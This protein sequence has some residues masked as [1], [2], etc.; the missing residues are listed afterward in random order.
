MKKNIIGTLV[1]S[2]FSTLGI[3]YANIPPTSPLIQPSVQKKLFNQATM[4]GSNIMLANYFVN[5]AEMRTISDRMSDLRFGIIDPGF[6]ARTYGGKLEPK[7]LKQFSNFSI[8]Y[9]G[10][11]FGFDKTLHQSDHVQWIIG[12]ELGYLHSKNHYKYAHGNNK[13]F[14]ATLYTTLF[15]DDHYY[16]E[17]FLKY[18]R[19]KNNYKFHDDFTGQIL[20][21]SN[22]S[23]NH[24]SLSLEAG[25]RWYLSDGN[26]GWY[27]EP[28]VQLIYSKIAKVHFKGPY[29]LELIGK[30]LNLPLLR[31]GLL[32]G[33]NFDHNDNYYNFY[34][35]INYIRN[36]KSDIDFT[37]Q[38]KTKRYSIKKNWCDYAVGATAT[39]NRRHTLGIE[40]GTANGHCFKENVRFSLSYRY[41][42]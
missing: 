14:N 15:T 6:Y 38:D 33:Y 37:F 13:S 36:F 31:A 39:F 40:A 42:F 19:I 35:K 28:Q 24:I 5:L 23:N 9:Y 7:S 16:L 25:K 30:E 4:T 12:A 21:G 22:K 18:S 10:A 1:L 26:R 20:K 2:C 41:N 8:E 11:Q 34:A 32:A 29:N 17:G 27:V 3:T